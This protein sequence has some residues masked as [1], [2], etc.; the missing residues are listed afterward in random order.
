MCGITGFFQDAPD[1]KIELI[2]DKM[3]RSLTR[4]GP[5]SHGIWIDSDQQ[6]AL[7]HTRLTIQDLSANGS[8]PM[9][10]QDQRWVISYNGEIY[11]FRSLSAS[12]RAGGISLRGTSDTEVVLETIAR[13]GVH[14]TLEQLNGM[15]AIAL[16]DTLERKLYLARDTFGIKPLYWSRHSGVFLFASQLSPFLHHPNWHRDLNRNSVNLFLKLSYI[17]A[18]QTIYE[19]TFKLLPG[20]LLEYTPA[21][22]ELSH[23][24][25]T[26]ETGDRH[27][28][29]SS[30][31]DA[32][33]I[34]TLEH[35]LRQTISNQMLV[36]V[37]VGSFLS[38]GVDSTLVTSF[39]QENSSRSIRTFSVGFDD[40]AFDES[41][42]AEEIAK[43]LGTQHTACTFSH[44]D[45]AALLPSIP[46]IYDEPFADS[47]QLPT[48]MVSEI[49]RET[50]K[51]ALS[52]DGGDEIFGGY[53]RYR[54]A[55]A[56]YWLRRLLPQAVRNT[57]GSWIGAL[58]YLPQN[59]SRA[60][61]IGVKLE[62]L[63][64]A[65]SAETDIEAYHQLL[66]N[67]LYSHQL[68]ELPPHYF[69]DSRPCDFSSAR[70]LQES[71]RKIDLDT[72]LPD[73]ILAKVDRAS[74]Y[75]SLE[76]RVPLLDIKIAGFI[77]NQPADRLVRRGETKW[78]L[79]SI[80]RKRIP[81]Q[82]FDRPKTGFSIPIDDWL[83]T[84]QKKW[85]SEILFDG[86]SA[87]CN[88]LVNRSGLEKAWS[89]HQSQ[90]SQYGHGLWAVANLFLWLNH[91]QI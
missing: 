14:R 22:N 19:N 41:G 30:Q 56:L 31:T 89:A 35:L 42:H 47:S 58:E 72:Y 57:S 65:L 23:S 85:I 25:F 24:V 28:N 77:A 69:T 34:E 80:L 53:E 59:I 12:L 29:L 90:S 21:T 68:G 63:S 32:E 76:V 48:L 71:M 40:K 54:M 1:H 70:E 20:T 9:V 36:D 88:S 44:S 6:V 61:H 16:W 74:M 39:M 38:G 60:R 13:I 15:F 49:A 2:C 10:S 79:R 4:R 51:V 87:E 27:V 26:P 66:F 33:A 91:N 50:V 11:N 83:R 75:R 55:G 45:I 52:G 84:S 8:Q 7:G 86:A 3:T 62:K 67:S 17:P 18:P 78:L 43:F 46:L 64:R 81:K 82:L 73:D 37:P 5:D